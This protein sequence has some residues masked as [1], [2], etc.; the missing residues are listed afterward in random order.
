MFV[1]VVGALATKGV[2]GYSYINIYMF[3]I[4]LVIFSCNCLSI[5]LQ[6]ETP[7]FP[8]ML[9]LLREFN[10]FYRISQRF[11]E[12]GSFVFFCCIPFSVLEDGFILSFCFLIRSRFLHICV[13]YDSDII[14][15]VARVHVCT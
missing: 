15:D 2:G 11:T 13:T 8:N 1:Y 7:L 5:R 9:L 12:N 6:L 10:T 3:N 4:R 14:C